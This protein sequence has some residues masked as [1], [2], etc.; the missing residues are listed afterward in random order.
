MTPDQSPPPA[1]EFEHVSFSFDDHAVLRDVSFTI[2]KGTM[3]V[4]LGESGAGKSVALKLILGLLRPD[5][6]AIR[7]NG[8]R[9]DTMP[10]QEL[11]RV[12]ADIGMVFQELALFDSLTVAEN[13]GYRLAE[14]MRMPPDQV[15]A[16]VEEVLGFIGLAEFIDRMPSALSGGQRRRV[17]IGR[18][19]AP[20]PD[21]ILF[22]DPTTGLDPIIASSVDD[23]IVKLRDLERVT[24]IFVTQQIRDAFYIATHHA[25]R[26]DGG[27]EIVGAE[28]GTEPADFMVLHEGRIFFRGSA[29]ELTSSTDPYLREF[30]YMT[31]PPW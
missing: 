5:S 17:A 4:L 30:L 10:E 13:V 27:I 20:R 25:V 8:Q 28:M 19:M 29:D 21:L 16:R 24:S 9:V 6:G 22:D 7:V 31:L 18:A 23:E 3:T 2:P 11:M 1:V 26:R 14:E 15:R 12:R